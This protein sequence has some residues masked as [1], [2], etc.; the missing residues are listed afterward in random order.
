VRRRI[1][2]L[3]LGFA[4]LVPAPARAQAACGFRLGF[5]ALRELA[6]ADLVGDCLEDEHAN[7][8]NGDALQ[9]TTRG[10]LVWR[11]LDNFTAFTDG[12]RTWVNGPFGLQER[13]NTERFDWEAVP[14]PTPAPPPTPSP[15]VPVLLAEGRG[16][17]GGKPGPFRLV[18]RYD[19]PLADDE[20]FDVIFWGQGHSALSI[21]NTKD[22]CYPLDERVLY[23]STFNWTIALIS[24]RGDHAVELRH[25]EGLRSFAWTR[26]P[27]VCWEPRTRTEYF[28]PCRWP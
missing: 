3:L 12:E 11:K 9:R 4:L 5:A 2:A 1:L 20:W 10:L 26:N 17:C 6:G 25:A 7:P 16:P 19:A 28:P 23:T 8:Q 24:R 22:T 14:A 18:W 13:R 15:P 21:A 27:D